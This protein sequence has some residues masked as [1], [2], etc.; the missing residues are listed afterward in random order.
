MDKD[1]INKFNKISIF[2]DFINDLNRL[3][4][5]Y[6]AMKVEK[7]NTGQ[8]IIKEG[9]IGDKLYI[10]NTG[11]VEIL[12]KTLNNEEYTVAILDSKDYIFFGEIALIDS[13]RRSASVKATTDCEVLSIDRESFI[14]LCEND[15]LMGYKIILQISKRISGTLRKM[16]KDVITLFEALVSEVEDGL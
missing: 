16:N 2:S 11:K 10:L 5:F 7:Y 4:M 6:N 8:Y 15:S 14:K 1:T 13:D 12:R 9:E 3:E